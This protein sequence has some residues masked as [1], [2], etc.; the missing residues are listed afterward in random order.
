MKKV[1]RIVEIADFIALNNPK[2]E[3]AT[4]FTTRRHREKWLYK[5]EFYGG[6][7]FRKLF[8]LKFK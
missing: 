4:V 1:D 2:I 3:H 5:I 8:I 7:R 6:K